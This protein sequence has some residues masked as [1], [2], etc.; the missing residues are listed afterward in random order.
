MNDISPA[1]KKSATEA[2]DNVGSGPLNRYRSA[3]STGEIQSDVAQIEAMTGLQTLFEELTKQ[4]V[5]LGVLAR[6]FSKQKQ[7]TIPGLSAVARRS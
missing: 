6:F 3:V 7:T 1:T 5:D 2:A 4:E